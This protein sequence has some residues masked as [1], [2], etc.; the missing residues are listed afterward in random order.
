M[1]SDYLTNWKK[2][3]ENVR[4]KYA[5]SREHSPK[6]DVPNLN[7]SDVPSGVLSPRRQTSPRRL[8]DFSGSRISNSRSVLNV[9]NFL[10]KVPYELSRVH[11]RLLE[12]DQPDRQKSQRLGKN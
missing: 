9:D 5:E 11:A 3:R 12:Q 7:I 6:R 10:K 1:D 8:L 4:K 2:Y